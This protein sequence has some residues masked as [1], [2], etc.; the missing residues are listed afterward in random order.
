MAAMEGVSRIKR[1]ALV[2]LRIGIC[3]TVTGTILFIIALLRLNSAG[4][5]ILPASSVVLAYFG[6]LPVLMGGSLWAI[7]WLLEGFLAPPSLE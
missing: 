2:M 6:F 3:G 5:A 1:A 4:P 7:A